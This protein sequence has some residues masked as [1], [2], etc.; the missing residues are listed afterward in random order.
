MQCIQER[1]KFPDFIVNAPELE[2]GLAL[3]YVA[4]WDLSS[5]R[6]GMGDGPIRWTAIAQYC[7]RYGLDED[8]EEAMFHHFRAMDVVVREHKN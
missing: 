7:D 6:G 1:T 2:P 8:Q 5:D 4:F 3:Y